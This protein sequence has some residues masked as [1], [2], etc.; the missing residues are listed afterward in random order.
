MLLLYG[1]HIF[2]RKNMKIKE[3]EA[4]D[5]PREKMIGNGAGAL[6]SAELMAV[7]LRTGSGRYNAV[8]TARLLLKS[9]G[10]SLV[11]LAGMSL[12]QMCK[13]CGVGPGKAVAVAAAFE[14][15]KR[16]AAEKVRCERVSVTHPDM[17]YRMMWPLLKGLQHE[18]C[19]VIY[20]NRANYV[21]A[22]ERLSSGG[23]AATVIDVKLILKKALDILASGLI[24]VHNHPSGN[25]HPGKNDIACTEAL[26]KAAG[27]MDITLYD[28]IIISDDRFFSFADERV[29]VMSGL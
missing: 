12:A 11:T 27:T 18:E 7:L 1:W 16:Y 13:T 8:E 4:D 15:G 22:K 24:I 29:E 20:L 5:R 21:I 10:G 9:A 25:P 23:L 19:W 14:L 2:V 3:L 6:S 17:V 26:K 28:H